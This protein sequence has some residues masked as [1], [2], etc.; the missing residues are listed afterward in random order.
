MINRTER[1]IMKNWGAMGGPVVSVCC[2]TFNHE[3]YIAQAIDGFLMQETDFPFEIIIRDDCST[4]QTAAIVRHYAEQYP[5]LIKPIY[6]QENQYSKGVKPMP[7][8]R[9]QAIGKY[10]ALC[11]GDDY[12]TDPKKLQLQ[13]AFLDEHPDY[14]VSGHDAFIVDE[15]GTHLQDSKL[16]D[17]YKRDYSGEDVILG[18]AWVLT[19]SLMVKNVTFDH[20]PE[21]GMV[22]NGDDF[23][24][25]LMG[26]FGKSH[27]HTDI[28][29]AGYRVHAGG[30]WSM[31]TD[32]EKRDDAMNTLF[33][34]YRYCHRIGEAK[35]ARHYWRRYINLVFYK[36]TVS[37]LTNEY[38]KKILQQ[39]KAFLRKMLV[40]LGLKK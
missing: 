8:A 22:K 6:E 16:P 9:K 12:W 18:K 35:Y 14:A 39:I 25:S 3:R 10:V 5:H 26:F 19:M 27:Y 7:V 17:M 1:E 4:D 37:E 40:R 20:I 33:W 36:S 38:L 15:A 28:K 32:V 11:E 34:K 23:F 13:V 29:P 31:L 21:F 30:V 2:T 24:I